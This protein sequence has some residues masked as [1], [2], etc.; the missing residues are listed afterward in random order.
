[1]EIVARTWRAL[2]MQTM[3]HVTSGIGA[4]FW[5]AFNHRS[6][7]PP[8]GPS[9]SKYYWSRRRNHNHWSDAVDCWRW[10]GRARQQWLVPDNNL[11][12]SRTHVSFFPF[13]SSMV[14][15]RLKCSRF[16][17]VSDIYR[18]YL[19]PASDMFVCQAANLG[20]RF[21]LSGGQNCCLG[22]GLP[23]MS[24]TKQIHI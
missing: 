20:H 19:V 24:Q 21:W 7:W 23:A 17:F 13:S 11:Y 3:F 5:S 15:G 16:L 1:M 14:V 12:G 8:T 4:P 6:E 22:D 18:I 10:G 2:P 9:T